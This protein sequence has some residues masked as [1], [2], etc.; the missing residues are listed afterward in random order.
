MIHMV[1]LDGAKL[2]KP[3]NTEIFTSVKKCDRAGYG[4]R[5]RYSR[6][7]TIAYYLEHGIDRVILGSIVSKRPDLVKEAIQQY[8]GDRIAVGID[9]KDGKVATEGWLSTSEVSYL[10]LA[11]SMEQSGVKVIIFTDI[12]RDGTLSGPNLIS[13]AHCKMQCPDIIASGGIKELSDIKNL[14]ELGLYGAICGKSLYQGTLSLRQA[15]ET[16]GDQN[17]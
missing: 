15:I 13:S 11:K 16:A 14:M 3:K 5:R 12:S 9:A 4:I 7:E 17:C 6:Y 10:D 2:A 1:D 8:G